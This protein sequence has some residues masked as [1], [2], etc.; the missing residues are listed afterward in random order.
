MSKHLNF[1]RAGTV[2][3]LLAMPAHAQETPTS[4]TVVATVNGQDITLGEMITVRAGLSE[5]LQSIP[6]DVLFD[7]ILEQLVQQTALAQSLDGALPKKVEIALINE[8]RSLLAAEALSAFVIGYSVDQTAL[9]EAYEEKYSTFVGDGE[10][11]ASHILVD[12]EEEATEIIAD[13]KAGADFAETAAAKS[14][15]PSAPSGGRLGWFGIGSMVKPF[16][17][18]VVTME[19]GAISTP[20][21]TQFGWHV[22]KLDDARTTQ[23]PSFEEER[24]AL[25]SEAQRR[26]VEAYVVQ[27]ASEAEVVKSDALLDP[28]LLQRSDLLD[29]TATQD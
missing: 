28:D 16:E 13:L 26:A 6:S 23:A 27:K 22:I 4:A 17:D 20:V 25:A 2:A 24:A 14:T 7:S 3:L 11:S 12:T 8:K 29:A 15:G 10:F 1:L 18:A 21:K 9:Q 5:R 19:I